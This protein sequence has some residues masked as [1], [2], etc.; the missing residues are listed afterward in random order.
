[1]TRKQL[2]TM[3]ALAASLLLAI[4]GEQTALAGSA[5]DAP[6]PPLSVAGMQAQLAAPQLYSV[7]AFVIRKDDECPP[8]PPH[9]VCE[10][11]QLGILIADNPDAPITNALYLATTQAAQFRTGSKYLFRIRYQIRKNA[12]GAWQLEGPQLVS[13]TEIGSGNPGR[14]EP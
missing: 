5:D 10:T 12:F 7:A 1:M 2:L 3:Q 6:T 13:Y 4:C 9:A 14:E 11:C 8:C